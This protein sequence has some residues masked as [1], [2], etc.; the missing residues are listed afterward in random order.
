MKT[1]TKTKSTHSRFYALLKQMHGVTKEDIVYEWS[2][3]GTTS[4]SEFAAMCPSL[5]EEMLKA[6]DNLIND[7]EA[8]KKA[9]SGVL[10]LLQKIGV[11]TADWKAVN[12][13]LE[14]PKIAGKRLWELH[15]NELHQLRRKLE[16]IL[17]K[18]T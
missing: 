6:M 16:S 14:S 2:D 1:K 8:I 9:R 7:T 18:T 4:L 10:H 15:L 13:Y 5:Y 12:A 11:N 3:G 17:F